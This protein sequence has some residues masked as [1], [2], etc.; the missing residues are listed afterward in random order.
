MRNVL[1]EFQHY[2][3]SKSLVKKKNITFDAHRARKFLKKAI[4]KRNTRG[5]LFL[6]APCTLNSEL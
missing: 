4:I 2:P 6:P 5:D 3:R 1:H